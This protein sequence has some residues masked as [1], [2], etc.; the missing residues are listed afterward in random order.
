MPL[1]VQH[2]LK[3]TNNKNEKKQFFEAHFLFSFLIMVYC[4]PKIC[5]K[6]QCFK[7][8]LKTSFLTRVQQIQCSCK[9]APILPLAARIRCKSSAGAH[10]FGSKQSTGVEVQAAVHCRIFWPKTIGNSTLEKNNWEHRP[11]HTI[12][13][14]GGGGSKPGGIE[15]GRA[16]KYIVLTSFCTDQSNYAVQSIQHCGIEKCRILLTPSEVGTAG[17]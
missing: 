16:S 13:N 15:C 1:K 14:S 6:F 5:P 2:Y 11:P 4:C 8:V 12:M 10:I 7:A 9:L 3:V 17:A